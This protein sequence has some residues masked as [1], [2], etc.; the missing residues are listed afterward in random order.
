MEYEYKPGQQLE[1]VISWFI[2]PVQFYI[3][4]AVNEE[5]RQLMETIQN[6]YPKRER[7]DIGTLLTDDCVVARDS[8][9]II[10]R[11]RVINGRPGGE[12]V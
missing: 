10:Y 9:N 8:D 12:Y 11:A 1:T 4:P 3:I 6:V 5:F 7:V 2:N